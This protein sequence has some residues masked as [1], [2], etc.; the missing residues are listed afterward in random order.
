VGFSRN[1]GEAEAITIVGIDEVDP[2]RRRVS[3]VSPIAKALIKSRQGDLLSLRT[4]QGVDEL[5]ILDVDY[6]WFAKEYGDV[7]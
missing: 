7:A 1:G 2:G 5:E 4:P 3:W 6:A